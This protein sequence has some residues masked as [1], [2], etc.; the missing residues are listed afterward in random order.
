MFQLLSPTKAINPQA[1]WYRGDFHVHSNFSD[2]VL[3]P[4]RL[5]ETAKSEGMEFFALT[6]HN[7]IDG[8]WELMPD[9]D[10]LVIPGLEVTLKMGH[11]NVLGIRG[12]HDWMEDICVYPYDDDLAWGKDRPPIKEIFIRAARQ[13]L[14]NCIVHPLKKS[15]GWHDNQTDL[16]YVHCIEVCNC[17]GEPENDLGIPKAIR[18]WTELLN[19]GYR[20]TALGGSDYHRTLPNPEYTGTHSREAIGL[21]TTYVYAEELSSN[22]I[23]SAVRRRRVYVSL[24]PKVSFQAQVNGKVYDIGQDV[25]PFRGEIIF[26]AIISECPEGTWAQIVR[27]GE[28]V[29]EGIV[30][31]GEI[32]LLYNDT[33]IPSQSNWYRLDVYDSNK[34]MLAITNPI[35]VGRRKHP[36]IQTYWEM[37]K[38][39]FPKDES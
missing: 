21:P 37:L 16:N 1:G 11:F 34:A 35:F 20:M 17:P 30:T 4:A 31:D 10:I 7:T 12:W 15:W 3:P 28:V 25:G 18:F 38:L 24:G 6:D 26:T 39:A 33:T 14:I 22:A 19:S 29:A 23:L 9:S 13:G 27:N 5:A 32:I 36:Q 8:L 2:G